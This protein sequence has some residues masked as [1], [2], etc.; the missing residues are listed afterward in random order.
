MLPQSWLDYFHFL[1]M[2]GALLILRLEYAI[3]FSWETV[4]PLFFPYLTLA[5]LQIS[6]ES[7]LPQEGLSGDPSPKV[8]M[9]DVYP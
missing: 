5:I 1:I 8:S 6:T 2:P 7:S 9:Y 3:P 4:L